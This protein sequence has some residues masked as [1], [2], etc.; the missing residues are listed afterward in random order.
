LCRIANSSLGGIFH[1][2]CRTGDDLVEK[3]V[4]GMS[5]AFPNDWSV[6]ADI[7]GQVDT[8]SLRC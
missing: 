3:G 6:S 8:I 4:I 7:G 5:V 1:R 2:S